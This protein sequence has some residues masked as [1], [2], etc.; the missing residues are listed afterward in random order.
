MLKNESSLYFLAPPFEKET[1][2]SWNTWSKSLISREL[3]FT[4]C[5][6][7]ENS[8]KQKFANSNLEIL[9]ILQILQKFAK[10]RNLILE[11]TYSLK[12][13]ALNRF[14]LTNMVMIEP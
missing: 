1:K 5:K 9:S 14:S 8:Q 11:K 10:L 2:H 4:N 6:N 12:V 13:I 3:N 7:D